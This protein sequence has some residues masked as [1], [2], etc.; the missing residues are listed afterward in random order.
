MIADKWT[1]IDDSLE[2]LSNMPPKMGT[3]FYGS[4]QREH[5]MQL[6]DEMLNS[7]PVL[8]ERLVLSL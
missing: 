7:D 2:C 8:R 4:K 1:L 3:G 6:I 5:D